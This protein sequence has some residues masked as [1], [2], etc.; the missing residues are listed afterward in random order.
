M[1]WKLLVLGAVVVLSAGSLTENRSQRLPRDVDSSIC[2]FK[3]GAKELVN[4]IINQGVDA[5]AENVEFDRFLCKVGITRD[6]F[7]LI[8]AGVTAAIVLCCC[9]KK[10]LCC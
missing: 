4:G 1:L 7:Y 5:R 10:C 8:L 3:A 2:D 9:I 6:Q